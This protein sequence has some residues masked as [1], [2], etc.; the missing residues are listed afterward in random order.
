MEYNW[1]NGSYEIKPFLHELI[2]KLA[3]LL[4]G[5]MVG[6]YLHGSL[7]MGGFNPR[8]SD[9]D[10]IVVTEQLLSVQTK[11]VLAQFFLQHSN[12]PFPIEIS[13]L[14]LSQLEN[15]RHPMVYDFH[16][17]EFWRER[18]EVELKNATT[19]Y[20][21]DVEKTDDDLAA[22][23]T[24]LNHRGICLLGRP[25]Q[26]IFPSIPH[27]HY[28]A[29]ILDDYEECLEKIDEC[30]VYCT[31]NLIRVYW[32][33]KDREICSK[34]EAGAWGKE[35][36]P[37]KFTGLIEQVTEAYESDRMNTVFPKEELYAARDYLRGEIEKVKQ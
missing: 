30:P 37:E 8:K 24:I 36:L 10:L 18:F 7:A 28:L 2:G 17:S 34:L 5:K 23:F 33:L 6:V 31:L 27:N 15:W 11:R 19:L 13:S 20:L 16:F 12:R 9:I 29:A 22:H 26:E 25:I 32:Y 21:N 4:D 35:N 3:V 1:D 14:S